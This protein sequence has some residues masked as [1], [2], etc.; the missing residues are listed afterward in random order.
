MEL[1]PK[2]TDSPAAAGVVTEL[3]PR[4][5]DSA[6]IGDDG[7]DEWMSRRY[8]LEA[9]KFVRL[10]LITTITGATSGDDGTSESITS[11]TDRYIL[12]AI[13]RAS[14]VVVVGAETVRIEGY[15]LP[16]TARL[17]V[18]TSTGDLGA[19]KLSTAGREDRPPALVLCPQDRAD[20][21]R[22]AI[23]DAPAEVLPLPTDGDRLAP[24][25]IVAGLR[26]QGLGRIVCEGGPELATQFVEAGVV[27]ELCVTVSPVLQPA[28]RPFVRL[29]DRVESTVAGMLVDDAGFSYLRLRVQG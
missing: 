3:F 22:H 2:P 29:T 12:G 4:S 15:L 5:L 24:R 10:N 7:T 11:R 16:K 28:H 13:R 6:R 21:V 1:A 23:G 25:T 26:A 20:A 17:A 14:D 8:A 18:V 27:D 19:G 9:E